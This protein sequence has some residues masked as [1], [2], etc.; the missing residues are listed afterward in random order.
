MYR[1]K[2]DVEQAKRLESGAAF[3]RSAIAV[4]LAESEREDVAHTADTGRYRLV[5]GEWQ[6][7]DDEP[8]DPTGQ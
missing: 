8:T 3:G 7:I 5:D 4:I 1:R 2:G 6:I